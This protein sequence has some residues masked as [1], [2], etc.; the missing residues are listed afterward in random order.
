MLFNHL[1]IAF[2]NLFNNKVYSFI[3]LAGLAIG[4]ASSIFIALFVIHEFSYDTFHEKA[5]RIYRIGV[6]GQMMGSE[7]NQAVTAAPMGAAVLQDYPEVENMVRIREFGDWLVRY[8]DKKFHEEDFLFADSTFF[9]VFDFKLLRGDPHTVLDEPKSVVLSESIAHKYFGNEDPIGKML[10]LETDTTYFRVTGIMEDVPTFSHFTFNMVGSVHTYEASRNNFWVSHNF[11]TYILLKEDINWKDLEKKL[12]G[13]IEKYVGPQIEEVLGIQMDQFYES[14]NTFGYFLQPVKSIHLESNLQY[15]FEPTGNKTLVYIFII[16]AILILVVASINFMNLSTARSAGRSKEVG[17]KK[18]SGSTQRT[19]IFQFL[20]ESVI[21][22]LIALIIA[23]GLVELLLHSFNNLIQ[24]SL[25][26]N[27]FQTWWLIPFLL[28]FGILVGVFAGTYPAFVLASFKPTAVLKGSLSTGVKGS[29]L[30]R[31]LVIG[32]FAVSISILLGTFVTNQQVR[33]ILNKDIGFDKENI[34]VIRRSDALEDQIDAFK[35][36]LMQNPAIKSVTNSGSIPGRNFS[37]NA[38]FKEG[39][40]T[41]NTYLVWQ[42][43]V[44][45]EFAETFSLEIIEGRFFSRE[46]ASDSS[47]MVLNESAVKSLGLEDP[48]GMRLMQPAGQGSYEYKTIIGVM[49]DFNFQTLHNKIEPMGLN[50]IP[51]NWEGYI[52]VK[53]AGSPNSEV[54]TFLKRTWEEF[55]KDYPFDYFWMEDDF[56]KQYETEIRTSKI[57]TIF[58]LLS[59]FVASLGL[60]GLISFTAEKRTKEIGIRK[61]LGATITSVLVLLSKET[62]YL[63][64]IAALLSV[65]FY[66]VIE[67]WLQNFAFHFAFNISVF[68]LWFSITVLIILVSAL[69]TVSFVTIGAAQRNPAEALRYE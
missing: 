17:I 56:T 52:P 63:V 59:L 45:Y 36:V 66:F 29:S 21:T 14:G 16:I 8:E 54:L 47:A 41:A 3:N 51:G 28:I 68:A 25:S 4:I 60:F 31:I 23:I 19:L 15:E 30:R 20:F 18:V 61:S 6:N 32:Q 5:D 64:G 38:I 69:V 65:P 10:H 7:I 39:E 43:W 49:R 1:K 22:S 53:M 35:E 24:L 13:L 2:R 62:V 55:N 50:L 27:Y 33:Y 57:L 46:M 44:N 34:L 67:K 9:E 37:N 12:N 42:S 11:Y 58:S 48:I 26:L 40:S